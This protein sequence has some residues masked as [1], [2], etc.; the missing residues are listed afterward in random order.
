[1]VTKITGI[2]WSIGKAVVWASFVCIFAFVNITYQCLFSLED[3]IVSK[4]N[5][6][7]LG[8]TLILRTV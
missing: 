5:L 7:F 4:W 8:F 2:I 1:M 3:K 6:S